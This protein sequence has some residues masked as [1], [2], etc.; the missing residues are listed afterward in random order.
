MLALLIVAYVVGFI[1]TE[2]SATQNCF[3]R[4]SEQMGIDLGFLALR[5]HR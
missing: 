3:V 2:H 4:V 1:D 5:K